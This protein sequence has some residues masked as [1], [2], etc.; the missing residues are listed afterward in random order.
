MFQKFRQFFQLSRTEKCLFVEAFITLAIIRSLLLLLPFKQLTHPLTRQNQKEGITLLP[1]STMQTGLAVSRAIYRAANNTPWESACLVQALS[2]HR[3][4]LK[5]DI[6][7]IF[8]LGVMKDNVEDCQIKAHAWTE[9]GER[10]ITGK[11]GYEKYNVIAVY[12]WGNK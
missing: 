9:V 6:P 8:Y 2:A 4:L 3:M 11:A 10:I 12:T 5:R 7:G 1:F